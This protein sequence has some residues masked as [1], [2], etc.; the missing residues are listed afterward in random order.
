[1]K[2]K[3]LT[4]ILFTL[5][6]AIAFS[7]SG[8]KK[9]E[10]P[11][12]DGNNGG[13]GSNNN[14]GPKLEFYSTGTVGDLYWTY[15]NRTLDIGVKVN[16]G[17]YI[18]HSKKVKNLQIIRENI[19]GPGKGDITTIFDTTLNEAYPTKTLVKQQLRTDGV[20]QA[21]IAVFTVKATDEDGNISEIKVEVSP[22]IT[23]DE[24]TGIVWD[25]D[26]DNA[27]DLTRGVSVNKSEAKA[28]HDIELAKSGDGFKFVSGNGSKFKLYNGSAVGLSRFENYDEIDAAWTASG[29][30]LTETPKLEEDP[31][32]Y[33]FILVKSTQN[34][35]IYIIQIYIVD[36]D[37][38]EFDYI[39]EIE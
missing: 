10:N 8:C 27:F 26:E 19:S 4:F 32:S 30:E 38:V 31:T 25:R 5:A 35:R 20:V 24:R 15:Q 3:K 13:G 39:G 6:I 23:V 22:S 12:S 18:T 28:T 11:D 1:M 21:Q 2:L 7:I 14:K 34:Q 37:N 36:I 33:K 29:A 17:V 16:M 9:K